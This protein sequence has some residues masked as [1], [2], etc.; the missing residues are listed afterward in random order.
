MR[1]LTH[2]LLQ[3]PKTKTYPLK[4]IP[5]EIETIESEFNGDFVRRMLPRLEWKVLRETS[6]ELGLG[7]LPEACPSESNNDDV[8]LR[9]L[10]TILMD[11]HIKEG[12]LISQDGSSYPIRDGI[13]NLL[14]AQTPSA[15][16]TPMEES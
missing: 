7:M 10:H 4:L 5:T 2:N 3:C 13:P 16:A 8:V 6:A 1:L 11:T 15:S 9:Q 14:I 12:V